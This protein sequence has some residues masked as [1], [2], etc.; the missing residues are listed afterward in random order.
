[1]TV[2]HMRGQLLK[3]LSDADKILLD[4]TGDDWLT[5]DWR[6]TEFEHR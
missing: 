5:D 6:C 3:L 4:F 2:L 1:M